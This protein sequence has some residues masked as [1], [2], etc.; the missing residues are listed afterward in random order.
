[1][2]LL[3]FLDRLPDR[4]LILFDRVGLA[5]VNVNSLSNSE[6][7]SRA[8]ANCFSITAILSAYHGV[9]LAQEPLDPHCCLREGAVA[10]N[11][12]CENDE[13]LATTHF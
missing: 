11:R 13:A 4:L 7:V 12:P 2:Y 10:L 6:C 9:P 1:M 5:T 3:R 8:G